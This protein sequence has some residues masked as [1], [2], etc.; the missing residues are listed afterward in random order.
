MIRLING[1]HAGTKLNLARAPFLLRV[2]QDQAGNI[3]ALDKV[4]D[5]ARPGEAFT[6]YRRMT[7][8]MIVH[9]DRR[10]P[11]TGRRQGLWFAAA[12]YRLALVQPDPATAADNQRWQ[13]WAQAN[14]RD[15]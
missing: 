8:P 12:D 13:A 6:I 11:K 10:D 1:P 14:R 3:D 4:E 15:S 7:K 9:L 2:V 5:T